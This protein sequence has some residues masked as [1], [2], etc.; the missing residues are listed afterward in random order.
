MLNWVN[1]NR[2]GKDVKPLLPEPY[3]WKTYPAMNVEFW[4]R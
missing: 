1:V 4:K 2:N 3:N